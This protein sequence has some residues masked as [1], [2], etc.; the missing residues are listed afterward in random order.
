MSILESTYGKNELSLALKNICLLQLC[1]KSLVFRFLEPHP[2]IP[3]AS[4][5]T[6]AEA[7]CLGSR[8]K[9]LYIY[10][11]CKCICMYAYIK[12]NNVYIY[13]DQGYLFLYFF[14]YMCIEYMYTSLSINIYIYICIYVC[15]YLI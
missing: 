1:F 5:E 9:C 15:M 4:G 14:I 12:K 8:L 13:I 10:C 3:P 7:E 6:T 2:M 11:I